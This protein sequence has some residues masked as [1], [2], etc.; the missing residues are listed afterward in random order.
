MAENNIPEP[1]TTDPIPS[2]TV[3]KP[4][5][6][7][8]P[9]LLDPAG[10]SPIGDKGNIGGEDDQSKGLLDT[11]DEGEPSGDGDKSKEENVEYEDFKVAE[12]LVPDEE[13]LS[14]AK[15]KFKELGLTQ[16]QAQGLIDLQ[17]NLM[18]KHH[19][20]Q[21][22]TMKAQTNELTRQW[23]AEVRADPELGGARLKENLTIARSAAIML[24]CP[25]VLQVI[26]DT[27]LGSNPDILRFLYRAGK[28]LQESSYTA[29][30]ATS[31]KN[32]SLAD[33][34]YDAPKK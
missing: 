9:S 11:A 32:V 13:T 19:R 4:A 1:T 28:A 17:N 29:A 34:M 25:E 7:G 10:D 23:D 6:E 31:R 12:G 22:E 3:D 15:T 21:L 24:E 14:L 20:E 2:P 27:R 30:K 18:L 8:D 26:K 33:I 16:E 5:G